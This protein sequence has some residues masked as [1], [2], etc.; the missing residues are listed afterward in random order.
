MNILL[1]YSLL[2]KIVN[3]FI[4]LTEMYLVLAIRFFLTI[5]KALYLSLKL[6]RGPILSTAALHMKRQCV[7]VTN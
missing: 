2:K 6:H 4:K 1:K 3:F 5:E 7:L